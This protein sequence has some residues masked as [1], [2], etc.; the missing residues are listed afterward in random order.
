MRAHPISLLLAVLACLAALS[1]DVAAADAASCYSHAV[2]AP[3]VRRQTI[4]LIDL[5]TATDADADEAFVQ[6]TATASTPPG[7]RY[8]V[9]SFSGLA[10]GQY[11]KMHL[12]RVVEAPITDP[13]IVETL[14]IRP[15]R[16]SQRCVE[17][18]ARVWPRQ[19]AD[20][21]RGVLSSGADRLRMQR[22]EIVY[23]LGEVLRT[24]V[25][26]GIE[27]T[28]LYV[29]SDGWE[30]GSLGVSMYG[31]D[32]RPRVINAGVELDRLQQRIQPRIPSSGALNVT[33]FGLMVEDAAA[34]DRYYDVRAV[35][36]M[37]D[38]WERLLTSMGAGAVRIDR[39]PMNQS[40]P[41]F[42]TRGRAAAVTQTGWSHD[43]K[44]SSSTR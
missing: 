40:E 29:Y 9:L 44:P 30:N 15:F 5:T 14:P 27:A 16:S 32:G 37:R 7:Q 21:V 23:S 20:A 31:K 25:H 10:S 43:S 42:T 36:Q 12:D 3:P 35:R 28:E 6:A 26:P 19:A 2:P 34:G 33:W 38:F 22:S 18:T 39:I 4:I 1:D 11:L 13:T 17:Q 24:F 8:V 41:Q